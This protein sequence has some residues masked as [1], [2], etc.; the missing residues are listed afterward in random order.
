MK[1]LG[2]FVQAQ[3]EISNAFWDFNV[4]LGFYRCANNLKS[5]NDNTII[6]I[7]VLSACGV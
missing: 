2:A 6:R 1:F 5:E 7:F 4:R 3:E